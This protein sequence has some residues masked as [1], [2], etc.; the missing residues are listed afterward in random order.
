MFALIRHGA[1]DIYPDH[2][3]PEGQLAITAFAQCLSLIHSWTHLK[4]SPR[5]RTQET[6]AIIGRVLGLSVETDPSLLENVDH[7]VWMPPHP[8]VDGTLLVTHIPAI[9]EIV[10]AW[11]EVFAIDRFPLVQ[12]GEGVMI[13]PIRK[14]IEKLV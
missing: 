3:T 8:I 12:V 11:A 2:L 5:V 4:A 10:T 7:G 14:T 13:D 6:A 1:H 9:R